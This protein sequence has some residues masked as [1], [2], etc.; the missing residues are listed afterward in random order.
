ML[1]DELLLLE[2]QLCFSLYAASKEIIKLYQPFLS[3]HN[4]TYTQ[5]ICL[6]VIWE[7]KNITVKELGNKLLLDSGTLTPLLKKME[8][9]NYISRA[10]SAKDERVVNISITEEGIR[11]KEKLVE[12]PCKIAEKLSVDGNELT[13]LKKKLDVLVEGFR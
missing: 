5:Y 2:N 1:K 7:E 6:L 9:N 12:V 8:K 11:L 3:P 13:L 10:R 4:L